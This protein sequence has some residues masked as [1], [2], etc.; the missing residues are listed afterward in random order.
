MYLGSVLLVRIDWIGG[1]LDTMRE[2]G[3]G[4]SRAAAGTSTRATG[5]GIGTEGA[6]REES[7]I[8][9]RQLSQKEGSGMLMRFTATPS[10]KRDGRMRRHSSVL[11]AHEMSCSRPNGLAGL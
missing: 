6:I 2:R 3:R 1:A 7:A 4:A 8:C 11:Y 5:V 9:A 10:R